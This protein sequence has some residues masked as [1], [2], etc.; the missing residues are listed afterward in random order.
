MAVFLTKF[1][2]KN[3]KGRFTISTVFLSGKRSIFLN[4]QLC[5]KA[6]FPD[7]TAFFCVFFGYIIFIISFSSV[8]PLLFTPFLFSS[9]LF[10]SLPLLFSP[11]PR[12]LPL[13]LLCLCSVLLSSFSLFCV[14]AG[15]CC[16]AAL[17]PLV[18]AWLAV[19]VGAG[20]CVA[21]AASAGA[22]VVSRFGAVFFFFDLSVH[23][24]CHSGHC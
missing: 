1:C 11:S 14:V 8:S 6:L 17:L 22:A 24:R 12:G 19:A 13:S 18:A 9:P 16:V 3:G 15:C 5:K 20:C 21:V 23:F 10:S 7:A 2:K 4:F